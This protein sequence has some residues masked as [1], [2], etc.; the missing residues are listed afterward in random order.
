MRVSNSDI[1][2]E[3]APKRET[4]NSCVAAMRHYLVALESDVLKLIIV[5]EMRLNETP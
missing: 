1:D 3:T 5:Q 2:T 4:I